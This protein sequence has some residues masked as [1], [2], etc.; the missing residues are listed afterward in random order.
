MGN[1]ANIYFQEELWFSEEFQKDK[2]E[3]SLS[4]LINKLLSIHYDIKDGIEGLSLAEIEAELVKADAHKA[5]LL[6]KQSFI[7]KEEEAKEEELRKSRLVPPF[8]TGN[9]FNSKL[10]R[11]AWMKEN[12]DEAE[13]W[14]T[15]GW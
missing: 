6:K 14:K 2:R 3:R 12:P 15:R 7:K 5:T 11:E 9:D 4:S 13:Y 10:T 8:P 1:V